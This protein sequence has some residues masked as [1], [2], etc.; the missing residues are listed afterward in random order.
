MRGDKNATETVAK[1]SHRI[2]SIGLALRGAEQVS[3][4]AGNLHGRNEKARRGF[5]DL[6][7]GQNSELLKMLLTHDANVNAKSNRTNESG[8]VSE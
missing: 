2:R 4:I 1:L 3:R 6:V 7:C 5:G 8:A